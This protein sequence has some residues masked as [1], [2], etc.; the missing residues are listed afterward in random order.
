LIGGARN[1]A[2]QQETTAE[3]GLTRNIK[4]HLIQFLENTVLPNQSFKIEHEW[5]GIMGIGQTKSP[6]IKVH[7]NHTYLAVRLGGM[8]V[9]IGS[10]VGDDVANLLH[11][12]L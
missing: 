2:E 8:G 4:E 11:S 7:G 5:S 10:L 3:F 12:S 6:I 9:A 1:K